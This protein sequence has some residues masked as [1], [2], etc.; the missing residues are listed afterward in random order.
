MN[1]D[2][3]AA[4]ESPKSFLAGVQERLAS[5]GL[6]RKKALEYTGMIALLTVIYYCYYVRDAKAC[7]P[8][9]ELTFSLMGMLMLKFLVFTGWPFALMAFFDSS[10]RSKDAGNVF[11]VSYIITDV[12]WYHKTGCGFCI[13]AASVRLIPYVL[14]AWIAHGLGALRYRWQS[15]S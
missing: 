12:I 6:S 4:D 5:I 11:L 14:C 3:H 7:E 13:F 9:L 1:T 15:P 10:W 8:D 2:L